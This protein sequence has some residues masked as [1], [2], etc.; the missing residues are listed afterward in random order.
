ME[1]ADNADQGS[2]EQADSQR[3]Q[4]QDRLHREEAFYQFVNNL[5]EEDYRL[6]RDNNLF[7]TPGKY[8]V[9]HYWLFIS[10]YNILFLREVSLCYGDT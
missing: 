8:A 1:G 3:R 2:S 5:S 6:M 4:Q 10:V 7:G 9:P